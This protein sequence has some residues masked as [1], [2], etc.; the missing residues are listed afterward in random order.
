MKLSMNVSQLEAIP[1]TY[2]RTFRIQY[3]RHLVRAKNCFA[4]QFVRDTLIV[5]PHGYSHGEAVK[6]TDVPI[7]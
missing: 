3:H 5:A 2:L 6:V 4:L 7:P 1:M